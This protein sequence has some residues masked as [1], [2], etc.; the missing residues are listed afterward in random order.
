MLRL[1][2]R[3]NGSPLLDEIRLFVVFKIRS[4]KDDARSNEGEGVT[5]RKE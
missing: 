4:E 1:H 5:R 2:V 3:R